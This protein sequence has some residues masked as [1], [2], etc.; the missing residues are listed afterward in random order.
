M[1][2][3]I[4]VKQWDAVCDIITLIDLW[5]Q[6]TCGTKNKKKKMGEKLNLVSL[7]LE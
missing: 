2:I 5:M 4:Q 1:L 3:V 6:N 7:N